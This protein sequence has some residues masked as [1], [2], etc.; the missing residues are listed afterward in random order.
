MLRHEIQAD[1]AKRDPGNWKKGMPLE[2][3]RD[4]LTRHVVDWN[5]AIE[6]GRM[7]EAEELACAIWF[8][9]AG[10]LEGRMK[11]KDV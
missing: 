10:W 1:G 2:A 4:S 5:R 7:D 3:W 11:G 8:N 9:V 6:A